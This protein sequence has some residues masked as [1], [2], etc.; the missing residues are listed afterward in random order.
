LFDE[1]QRRG[2]PGQLGDQELL[3]QG[4]RLPFRV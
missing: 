1:F 4:D 3:R 2:M